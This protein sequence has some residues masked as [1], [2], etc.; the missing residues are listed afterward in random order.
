MATKSSSKKG[1]SK[2]SAERNPSG[3]STEKAGVGTPAE[4]KNQ[5]VPD[6]VLIKRESVVEEGT[7]TTSSASVKGDQTIMVIDIMQSRPV[8]VHVIETKSMGQGEEKDEPL[9]FVQGAVSNDLM[10][11]AQAKAKFAKKK[12]GTVIYNARGFDDVPATA[13]FDLVDIVKLVDHVHG[14]KAK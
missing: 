6:S 11:Y 1:A 8:K 7:K 13:D 5:S 4:P 9:V 12:D 3:R 2:K 10:P 14:K